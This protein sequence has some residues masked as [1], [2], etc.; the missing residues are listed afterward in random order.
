MGRKTINVIPTRFNE[1]YNITIEMLTD[2]AKFVNNSQLVDT[3]TVSNITASQAP[4]EIDFGT[5]EVDVDIKVTVTDA[6][7]CQVVLNQTIDNPYKV[8]CDTVEDLGLDFSFETVQYNPHESLDPNT[9]AQLIAG[10][11][12]NEYVRYTA[13][14]TGT[15]NNAPS[16]VSDILSFSLDGG[17]T[18]E[19]GSKVSR[20][21]AF[22]TFAKFHPICF[23]Q[24]ID[25]GGGV[26][27]AEHSIGIQVY[28]GNANGNGLNFNSLSLNEQNTTGAFFSPQNYIGEN[29]GPGGRVL[30][31]KTSKYDEINHPPSPTNDDL[32]AWIQSG[33]E[34]L[35]VDLEFDDGYIF[36]ND[37][38]FICPY[39][40][41][42]DQATCDGVIS[43][44]TPVVRAGSQKDF[45]WKRVIT[46]NNG[47]PV[48]TVVYDINIVDIVN[49]QTIPFISATRN[50]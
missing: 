40:D 4:F 22:N 21:R 23:A 1:H 33:N 29:L 28:A 6:M 16:V 36:S 10:L 31:H 7:D 32:T 34:T 9:H 42:T 46:F 37:W 50:V 19:N 41:R 27:R 26:M 48:I 25:I 8:V 13:S 35:T 12:N 11:A 39:A 47:C 24:M 2:C 30:W 38:E 44:N 15:F 18:W 5:C 3:M 43:D 20:F 17:T 14:K 49:D 45:K